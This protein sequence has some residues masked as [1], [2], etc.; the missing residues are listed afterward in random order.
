[1]VVVGLRS[2]VTGLLIVVVHVGVAVGEIRPAALRF[3][4]SDIAGS[5]A[6]ENLH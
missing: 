1:M 4:F 6:M 5:G 3:G 2:K